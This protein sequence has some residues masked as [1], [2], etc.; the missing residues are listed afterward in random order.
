MK[1][2]NGFNRISQWYTKK[3]GRQN[4]RI[5]DFL[6]NNFHKYL[7]A[8]L[9]QFIAE[10][11]RPIGWRR[12]LGDEYV[13]S[14]RYNTTN[15][16]QI[17]IHFWFLLVFFSCFIFRYR[18]I[19]NGYITARDRSLTERNNNNKK[20]KTRLTPMRKHFGKKRK[21]KIRRVCVCVHCNLL[22]HLK[23]KTIVKVF[24]SSSFANFFI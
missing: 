15:H 24:A 19:L 6:K 10:S 12:R 11:S 8:C 13:V 23:N 7:D 18:S 16:C 5:I 3:K 22:S 20:K 17:A 21:K 1:K 14:F 2:K 4:D 9:N